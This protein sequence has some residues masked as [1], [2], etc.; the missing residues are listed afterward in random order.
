M[1]PPDFRPSQRLSDW[2]DCTLELSCQPCG[3]RSSHPPVKLLRAELGDRTF[4]EVLAKLRCT[5]G[6]RKPAPVYLVAGHHRTACG[7]PAPDWAIE[8]AQPRT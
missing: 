5:H 4:E 7:G 6:H 8:L 3:G 1:H 2:P